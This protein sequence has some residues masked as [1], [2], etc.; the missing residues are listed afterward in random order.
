M[1]HLFKFYR[2]NITLASTDTLIGCLVIYI[3]DQWVF[4]VTTRDSL[5]QVGQNLE[6]KIDNFK[7]DR[8][9]GFP[10]GGDSYLWSG[11]I[12]CPINKKL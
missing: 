2:V 10:K 12:E 4:I 6:S 7:D 11:T 9:W 8:N 3:K 5:Q 1:I